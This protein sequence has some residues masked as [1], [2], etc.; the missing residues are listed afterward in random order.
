MEDYEDYDED[1]RENDP[2]KDYKDITGMS[3]EAISE[4]QDDDPKA[5]YANLARQSRA[6]VSQESYLEHFA[7]KHPDFDGLWESETLQR[8]MRENAEINDVV[9]AYYH[10]Q[11]GD[12]RMENVK[13]QGGKAA[14]MAKRSSERQGKRPGLKR[15]SM[16][17]TVPTVP[18][19]GTEF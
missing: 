1:S 5:F 15:D 9:S 8:I 18:G 13:D 3:G 19:N 17:D 6:E 4:W 7:A 16:F 11:K 12:K 2:G 10:F 14:L